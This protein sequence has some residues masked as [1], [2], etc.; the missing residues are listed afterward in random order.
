MAYVSLIHQKFIQ[1]LHIMYCASGKWWWETPDYPPFLAHLP[2]SRRCK[3][4][5]KDL[6]N[7]CVKYTLTKA[8][9]KKCLNLWKDE[10]MGITELIS[11]EF[12]AIEK[13]GTWMAESL[14]CPP[15]TLTALLIGYTPIRS[16]K[17]NIKK[18]QFRSI[19]L[20]VRKVRML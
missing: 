14:C 8:M 9:K 20:W 2:L 1:Y 3:Y 15:E 4:S 7:K 17:F 10:R 19:K 12:S 18:G 11:A 5:S 6:P 13:M 16:K